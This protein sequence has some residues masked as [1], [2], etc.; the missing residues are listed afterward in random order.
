MLVTPYSFTDVLEQES[1]LGAGLKRVRGTPIEMAD[2]ELARHPPAIGKVQTE[3]PAKRFSF[4]SSSP[5]PG[6]ARNTSAL[7]S[8]GALV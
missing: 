5:F 7:D 2:K 6:I 1:L 3:L 8:I 4:F